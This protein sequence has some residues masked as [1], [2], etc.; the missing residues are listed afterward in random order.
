MRAS[1]KEASGEIH[2]SGAEGIYD[3]SEI[4]RTGRDFIERSLSHPRGKPDKIVVTAE[5][6][7]EEIISAPLLTVRTLDCESPDD[8]WS[9]ICD[10]LA[11]LGVSEAALKSAQRVL[12]SNKTMRGASL[13]DVRSGCRLEHDRVRGVRVSRFGIDKDSE[14]KLSRRLSHLRINTITVKEALILASKVS[15]CENIVAEICL[16][17]DPDYTT[18]YIAS[19]SIGYLR[20]PNIKRIGDMHGGRVFFVN[21]V[22]DIERTISWLERRPVIIG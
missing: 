18:G 21:E 19:R 13:I 14:M 10:R 12:K 7:G 8:A 6:L 2:I 16:S 15:A 20:I 22:S 9:L 1:K 11:R 17:D 5:K 4:S 3:E